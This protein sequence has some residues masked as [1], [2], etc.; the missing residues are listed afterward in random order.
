MLA[1]HDE[2]EAHRAE[3]GDAPVPLTNA[4][5]ASSFVTKPSSGGRPAIDSAARPPAAAVRG[6]AVAGRRAR[7]RSR[8][9]VSWSTTPT[10]MNSAA[11]NSAWASDVDCRDAERERGAESHERGQSP[12]WLT[13][14]YAMSRFRSCCTSATHAPRT[15][16]AHRSGRGSRARP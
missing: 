16:V 9:P 1:T 13:V 10:V 15:A 6:S 7:S 12:S 4:A 14:E 11:L 3:P 2:D 5:S 8:V